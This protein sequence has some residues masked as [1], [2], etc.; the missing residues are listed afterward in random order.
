VEANSARVLARLFGIRE[1]LSSAR[2]QKRLWALAEEILPRRTCAEHNQAIMDLGAM[3]CRA[4]EPLCHCCPLKK[5]CESRALG[6]TSQVPAVASRQKGVHIGFVGVVLAHRGRFLVHRIPAGH[7]HAGLFEFPKIRTEASGE[8][9]AR[10]L[11]KKAFAGVS[12]RIEKTPFADV[13]YTITH[14]YVRLRLWR[15]RLPGEDFRK[16]RLITRQEPGDWRW[17]SLDELTRLPLASPQRRVVE[18][19]VKSEESKRDTR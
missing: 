3:V 16:W 2:T 6:I 8:T 13:R 10:R 15:G 7:W 4:K 12:L 5:V 1:P 19:L 11:L 17:V 18:I 9:D 14:H